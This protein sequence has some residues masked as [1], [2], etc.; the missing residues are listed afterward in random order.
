VSTLLQTLIREKKFNAAVSPAIDL[1]ER[2]LV[3]DPQKR[4]TAAEALGHA[5]LAPYH[6][7][8][9]EP[10]ADNVFDW[11]FTE[12]DL[13]LEQWKMLMYQVTSICGCEMAIVC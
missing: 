1:L 4:I 3:F 12:Q 9:D 8:E 2:M 5:Y 10:A 6:D 7:P 13:S 11:S